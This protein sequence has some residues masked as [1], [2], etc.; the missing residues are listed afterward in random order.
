MEFVLLLLNWEL[1]LATSLADEDFNR[2]DFGFLAIYATAEDCNQD[3]I[4]RVSPPDN[5]EQDWTVTWKSGLAF[6]MSENSVLGC[7]PRINDYQESIVRANKENP[8]LAQ[9]L[10][11][12]WGEIFK[13]TSK[14]SDQDQTTVQSGTQENLDESIV[15]EGRLLDA[16]PVERAI[17]E[18]LDSM[19]TRITDK[20]IRPVSYRDGLEAFLRMSLA[21]NGELVDVKIVKTSGDVAFDRSAIRAIKRAA[22]F[23]EVEQFNDEVFEEKFR[24]LTVKFRPED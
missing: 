18:A 20:W 22:P 10:S 14:R 16:L 13:E 9:G 1:I 15:A 7:L 23:E 4:A 2:K 12:F 19:I 5:N 11:N 3:L 21:S 6:A 17:L 24:S 8:D